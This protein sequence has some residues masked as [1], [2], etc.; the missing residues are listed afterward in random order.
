MSLIIEEIEATIQET[1]SSGFR[2]RL[3]ERGLSRSMIWKEGE[4][5]D[6]AP[7]YSHVL[8]YDLLSYG[9]SLLSL[10]IRLRD[11]GGNENL[12]RSAF[13]KAAQAISNIIDNG[14]S[15][16]P[17]YGFH[18]VM[19]ASAYHLGRFS[20][21]AYSL[22]HSNL[23]NG[24]VSNME[25]HLCLLML[26]QFNKLELSIMDWKE[27]GIAADTTLAGKLEAEIE[28][29]EQSSDTED[30]LEGLDSS[31]IEIPIID[32]ALTDNYLSAIFEFIFALEKGSS[33]LQENAVRRIDNSL[34]VSSDL[35]MLPQWWVLRVTK[36]LLSDLWESS[37]HKVIPRPSPHDAQNDW[38][39]LRMLF[40]MSLFKRD[41]SEVDLWPSQLEGAKRAV[42]DNDNLVVSLP[43]SAGKTRIAELCILRCLAIHK[44]VLFI[45]PLRAL[46]AQTEVT[47]RK[48]FLPLGKSVSSLYGSMG[49]SDFEQDVLKTKDIVVGTP[50][51]LDFALRS[52]PTIIN[53][54]G[55]IILDEGH[56]I[57]LSER[58]INYE[59]QIQR[60]LKRSDA[61]QRRIVCLSA[62]LPDNEQFD[63]FV[64]WIR[65]DEEGCGIQSNWR[66]T[67]LRFG[68][69]IWGKKS[70]QI[71]FTIGEEQPFI[72]NY[73][74]S[75]IPSKPN[76]GIRK[77][78]FPKNAQELT[79]ATAWRL[80]QDD[81][82]VLIYCPQ[83][84]SV[85]AFAKRI[86]DL[87]E[88]G[89]LSSVLSVQ[90]DKL[91]L[92]HT[93][94]I[95]WL[96]A[97][98][99]IIKCLSLGVAIHHGGLPTPFRKEMEKLLRKGVL[100][101]TVSSPTLAQGLN[102]SATAIIIHSLYRN[103]EIIDASEL[104]NVVGRAGRAFVDTH[105]LVLH[106]IF[107]RKSWRKKQWTKL[108]NDNNAQIMESGLAHLVY[109][110]VDRI[111]K[112]L[113]EP[114]DYGGV[115]EY[116]VNNI[117]GWQCP[118]LT[119]EDQQEK[120]EQE[121][122]W[123]K[124][125]NYLD[126][127]LLS[128]LGDAEVV[129]SDIAGSL[130]NILNSSLWERLLNRHE[131]IKP[132]LNAALVQRG[133]YI[134]SATTKPQRMGFFLAGVGLE[135][136]VKLDDISLNANVLLVKANQYIEARDDQSAIATITELAEIIF[137]IPPFKPRNVPEDWKKIIET[138]L[139]GGSL[140]DAK[141]I[142]I[143]DSLKF[144]EDALVYRI[145]WGL[146]AIRVRAMANKDLV[147]GNKIEDYELGLVI[148][149][150]ENGTLNRSVAILMQ[151]GFNSRKAA[152]YAIT[153]TDASFTNGHQL[154]DWLASQKVVDLTHSF[155]WPTPETSTLWQ[156]FIQGYQPSSKANW[157][158]IE[159]QVN[160]N[161]SIENAPKGG[162]LV[163][164]WNKHKGKTQI[165]DSACEIVGELYYRYNLDNSGIYYCKTSDDK[166]SL[167]L[168]YVGPCEDPFDK[169]FD[170]TF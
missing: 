54:V 87:H 108:V 47:L 141:F 52:D 88:R 131:S 90:E 137:D 19:A 153:T 119:G 82:T 78:P 106:P 14:T 121:E 148:P 167:T 16:D 159:T 53:D 34:S 162:A 42:I 59:I 57:G 17:E 35:N 22:I 80:V 51:K 143:D 26:R 126:T 48:T 170:S 29:L 158:V 20:A 157:A 130:D 13:E 7:N 150:I 24:N 36:H 98:H 55:L 85:E 92:A 15:T 113:G 37:F 112:S 116:I 32:L 83:K 96:G 156:S 86:L 155:S 25:K 107:D 50:E 60:L 63:D 72:P 38:G 94:G 164:I 135:T 169:S 115:L 30:D 84:S 76:P 105:G 28:K 49:T 6:G 77:S 128:L 160:V 43:T 146:E 44:R 168:T 134:W 163:K 1:I 69:I 101:I 10:A 71:N 65:Q 18:M 145:P 97:D 133:E 64:G 161:W 139:N 114:P 74:N 118:N 56:M 5:P 100:K 31:S 89:A 109:S 41:K 68:E 8:S 62:I 61:D 21:K 3:L 151:A 129:I 140:V 79:L 147:Y 132:L 39:N 2:G 120:E 4:L 58:E 27:S 12:C 125:I 123:H 93:L 33:T 111:H 81:H 45:T 127:A 124:Y 149:A 9:Y 102:L 104:K 122:E 11:L 142:N 70:G 117:Q 154:N 99:P 110:L 91:I 95:E 166:K 103:G 138:W 67:D 40:I 152:V 73:I 75:M 136:G 23:N 46:S 165:S 144:I 66:P